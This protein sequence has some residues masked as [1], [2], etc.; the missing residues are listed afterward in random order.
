MLIEALEV[1]GI[2]V[3][4]ANTDGIVVLTNEFE[5][6]NKICEEWERK[7]NL[8]LEYTNYKALIQTS[9]NDYNLYIL[10]QD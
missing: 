10:I 8:V 7:T 6:Y 5:K 9:V 2:K 3:I 4:S 1:E